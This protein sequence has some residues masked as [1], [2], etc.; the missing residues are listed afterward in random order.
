MCLFLP[1][2]FKQPLCASLQGKLGFWGV[3][4]VVMGICKGEGLHSN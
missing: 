4:S 1:G 3:G 2:S